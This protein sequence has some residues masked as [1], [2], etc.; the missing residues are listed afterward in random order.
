MYGT[1]GRTRTCNP[2][3]R[4]PVLYPVEPRGHTQDP[5]SYWLLATSSFLYN[6]GMSYGDD[7]DD[8]P[9]AAPSSSHEEYFTHADKGREKQL[10]EV[11]G[12]E[13]EAQKLKAELKTDVDR[14]QLKNEIA[15]DEEEQKEELREEEQSEEPAAHT[16][17]KEEDALIQDAYEIPT[18]EEMITQQDA[19]AEQQQ[20][21]AD[22]ET[23]DEPG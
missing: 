15:D 18:E 17:E 4:R 2:R 1:R 19:E 12:V 5:T 13:A 21:V 9:T 8:D 6:I 11:T 3:F 22:L 16:Q 20:E 23:Q 10:E 14:E 7:K